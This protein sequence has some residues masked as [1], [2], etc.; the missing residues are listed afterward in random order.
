MAPL[1]SEELAQESPQRVPSPER[2][3]MVL[4]TFGM[5]VHAR[6]DGDVQREQIADLPFK[7]VRPE[8]PAGFGVDELRIHAHALSRLAYAAFEHIAYAELASDP[9]HT[10]LAS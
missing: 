7:A 1:R 9:L 2:F 4:L 3:V 8:I 5:L 6:L 10:P